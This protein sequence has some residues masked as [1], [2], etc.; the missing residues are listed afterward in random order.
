MAQAPRSKKTAGK[1][2][3]ASARA[4]TAQGVQHTPWLEWLSAGVG[5]VLILATLGLVASELFRADDTPPRLVVRTL[6]VEPAPGGFHVAVRVQNEGGSPAASVLVEGE[7][8][9]AVG[10]A[11]TAEATFDFVADHSSRDGG[12][13]FKSDPRKG[14]LALRAKG[15]S[16]P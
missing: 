6:S 10:E 16:A 1:R 14:S 2:P 8:T 12:L 7:L 4:P 11:E 3:A 13:Y 5:L 9:P 15:Y